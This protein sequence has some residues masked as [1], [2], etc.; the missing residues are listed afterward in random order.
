MHRNTNNKYANKLQDITNHICEYVE[1]TLDYRIIENNETYGLLTGNFGILI[2]LAYITKQY[3][4]KNL[5]H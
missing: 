5:P 1:R 4:G 2:F 3:F